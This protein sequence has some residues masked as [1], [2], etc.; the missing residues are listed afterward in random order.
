MNFAHFCEFWCFT[1]GKQARFTLNFC[2]GMPL[3]KV[4][5]LTFFGLVCRG[6]SWF[7]GCSA[8][9][10]RH[11][12]NVRRKMRQCSATRVARHKW[13]SI[14][15][16]QP[17]GGLRHGETSDC[18][19]E[20]LQKVFCI[21]GP[22]SKGLWRAFGTI[23][24]VWQVVPKC[25][26]S[27][28]GRMQK[29]A[30]ESKSQKVAD[31]WKKDVWDF[32]V[33]YQTLFELQLKSFPRKW[34]KRRQ[35]PELPDLAWKSQTCFSQTSATPWKER[36]WVQKS[37]TLEILKRAWNFQASHPP[38]PYFLWG[39]LEVRIEKIQ[40]R[41]KFSSEIENFKRSWNFSRFGPL[42]KRKSAKKSKRAQ[43]SAST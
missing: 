27:K 42:G 22:G 5:E 38:N 6:D 35:E 17:G 24:K 10:V 14:W 3:R 39:I 30:N 33:L 37:T 18:C 9:L 34:R 7:K 8:I 23:R 26:R 4:H 21:L 31:V 16:T 40:E 32:Q 28:R 15:A 25:S 12:E 19:W 13:C 1:L 2:S 43:K 11:C 36:K 20:R 41:L 29:H